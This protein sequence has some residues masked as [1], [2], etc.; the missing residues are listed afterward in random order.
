MAGLPDRYLIHMDVEAINSGMG[1]F[2]CHLRRLNPESRITIGSFEGE[3]ATNP[4][5]L[6]TSAILRFCP[7]VGMLG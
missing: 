5:P 3:A 2:S 4:V 1:Q 7:L 6:A